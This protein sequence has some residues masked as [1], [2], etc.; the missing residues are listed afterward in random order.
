METPAHSPVRTVLRDTRAWRLQVWVSFALALLV[1]GSGLAWLPG[2]DLDRAF[3]VM[4]YVFCL[5]TAFALAKFVRDNAE[6]PADT[7]LW[8]LVVWGGFALAMALTGWGLWRMEINPTWKAYLLVSWLYLISTAFTL[9]K[10]LRDAF[11]AERL[12]HGDAPATEQ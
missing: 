1:C 6:R 8:S 11:E 12:E 9:A 10:T 4:G 5:S 7:P 2:A 3:M